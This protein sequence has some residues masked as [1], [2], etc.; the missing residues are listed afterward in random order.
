MTTNLSK[1][2]REISY[3]SHLVL[4]SNK[5][6]LAEAVAQEEWDIE[7]VSI[8]LFLDEVEVR[9][10]KIEPILRDWTNRM[11]KQKVDKAEKQLEDTQ[12]WLKVMQD[13]EELEYEIDKRVK[14]KLQKMIDSLDVWD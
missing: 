1:E 3:L 9:D 5:E 7:N 10:E 2:F 12:E 14:E 11:Y 13:K 8:R 6:K 4:E